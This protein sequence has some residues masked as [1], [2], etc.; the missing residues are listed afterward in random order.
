MAWL[1]PLY[2]LLCQVCR[3]GHGYSG[4]C[5]SLSQIIQLPMTESEFKLGPVFLGLAMALGVKERIL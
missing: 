2:H 3:C 1:V 4:R 5:N